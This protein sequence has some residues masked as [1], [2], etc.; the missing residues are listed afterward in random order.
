M[1]AAI[2][3]IRQAYLNNCLPS[4]QRATLLSFDGLMSSVGGSTFQPLL[5]RAADVWGY[6]FSFLLAGCVQLLALPFVLLS[7]NENSEADQI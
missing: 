4:K 3:P 7:K 6:G 5:G 1:G 2:I